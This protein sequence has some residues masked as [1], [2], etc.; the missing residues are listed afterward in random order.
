MPQA[1]NRSFLCSL[2]G[3]YATIVPNDGD[4]LSA[5]GLLCYS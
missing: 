4:F 2:D 1:V 5:P 3:I